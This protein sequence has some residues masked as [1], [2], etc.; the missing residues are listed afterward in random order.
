MMVMLDGG[1]SM[2]GGYTISLATQDDI[3]GILALQEPNL[4]ENGGSLSVLRVG[5]IACS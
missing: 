4:P 5:Q 2:V 3:P 1:H